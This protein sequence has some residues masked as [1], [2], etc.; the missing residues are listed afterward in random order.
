MNKS[1]ASHLVESTDFA[2]KY[3]P[4]ESYKVLSA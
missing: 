2:V 4:K 1:Y 3:E